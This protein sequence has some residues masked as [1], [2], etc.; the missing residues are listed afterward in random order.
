MGT[1]GTD[2][3][4]FHKRGEED[5]EM[6]TRQLQIHSWVFA[7]ALF[8]CS[9][10]FA[11][12]DTTDLTGQD[13][14]AEQL[15][16]A[17]NIRTRGIEAKCSPYQEQMTPLTRGIGVKPE[18]VKAAEDVPAIE[19][20]RTASVSATFE[21]NSATL[22]PETEKLLSTVAVALNSQDLSAQCFQ[23]AGHTCDL[24]DDAYNMQ[25]SR[26]RADTVKAYLIE[27][28]VS[29]DRLITTGYGETVPMVPNETEI[30]R[31][32]NRRVD[33]G[34]LAPVAMEYQ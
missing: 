26:K 33:L 15:V 29:E 30:S 23:L 11:Q 20:A 24:G 21:R 10:S 13:V 32:K 4:A 19:P 25:L 5:N 18:D 6:N 16:E 2:G 27:K 12:G 28:G 3:K 22:T 1:P 17:L 8:G 7:A 14:T 31:E 34:A 9:L